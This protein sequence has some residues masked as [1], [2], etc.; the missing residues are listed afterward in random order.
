[1]KYVLLI[2]MLFCGAPIKAQSTEYISR[3][4]VINS[5]D[6]VS[7]YHVEMEI[8][9]SVDSV[10]IYSNVE[11]V[12]TLLV[13]IST[14][15]VVGVDY[16]KHRDD[17]YDIKYYPHTNTL[18]IENLSNRTESWFYENSPKSFYIKK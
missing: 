15:W 18:Y 4:Q 3:F 16:L 2:F 10:N 13:P 5:S 6:Q 11:G 12:R 7:V 17:K 14:S 8:L 1:M 9:I